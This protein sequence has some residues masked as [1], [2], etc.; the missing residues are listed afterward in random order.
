M[1]QLP[2]P[3]V[4]QTRLGYRGEELV[5][6]ERAIPEETPVA[7]TYDGTTYAVM[8][9]TP[10]DL[11]DFAIGFT[12][13]EGICA[14][15]GEIEG[16]EIVSSDAG[17]EVRMWIPPERGEAVVARRRALT[18]PV[19]CGLCGIDSLAAAKTPLPHVTA[20]PGVTLAMISDAVAALPAAQPLSLETRAVH[21]AGFWTPGAGLV[22]VR[23]DV[24]RHNALDK[25]AGALAGKGVDPASGVL[26]LTSRV[27]VELIQKAA[28]IGV[29][30]LAAISA[31]TAL[32]VREAEAA[33][34][35]LIAVARADGFE[36]FTH[37]ERLASGPTTRTATR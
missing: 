22:A 16:P 32:A 29:G 14:S 1:S 33:N 9:A 7:L 6:G 15:A 27:S 23:E 37:P 28:R 35:T 13:T 4:R 21:A 12:L 24:G 2:P 18:G 26:L 3:S 17:I 31:P 30:V 8:M 25:L 20:D 5:S 34:I 11:A 19:G 10:A 36:I